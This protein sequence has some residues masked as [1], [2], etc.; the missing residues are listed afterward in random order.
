MG[1][2]PE[3]LILVR[4][5]GWREIQSTALTGFLLCHGSPEEVFQERAEN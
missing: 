2:V 5:G 3:E 1:S 4:G